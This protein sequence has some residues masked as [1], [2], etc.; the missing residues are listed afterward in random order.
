MQRGVSKT[1][2]RVEVWDGLRALLI[3]LVGAF[4]IWQQSWL[5]PGVWVFGRHHSL[6]FLLRS[7]YIWVDGMILLSGFLIYLPYARAGEGEK[8]RAMSLKL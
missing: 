4:H 1:E 7:G 5:T 6:D 3:F 8:L 2:Q